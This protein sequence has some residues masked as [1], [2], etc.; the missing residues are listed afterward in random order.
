L[1][2]TVP[3]VRLTVSIHLP[4][5]HVYVWVLPSFDALTLK[6]YPSG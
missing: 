4:S 3:A 1:R 6:L 5:L 2:V